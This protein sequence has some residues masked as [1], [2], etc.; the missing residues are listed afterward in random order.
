M[1]SCIRS[2][3]G[4]VGRSASSR[5]LGAK[6]PPKKFL[7]RFVHGRIFTL[8]SVGFRARVVSMGR[9]KID[10]TGKR[11]GRLV[12]LHEE[13]RYRTTP[14]WKCECDCGEI[15]IVLGSNLRS[16]GTSSC[17]CLRDEVIRRKSESSVARTPEYSCWVA[18][19]ERTNNPE[20]PSY[21]RYGGVGISMCPQWEDFRKFVSDMGPRPSMH[22]AIERIGNMGNY[23]PDNC[24]WAT[25]EEQGNSRRSNVKVTWKGVSMTVIQWER[26]LGMSKRLLRG[27]IR[28]GWDIERALTEGIPPERV[29]Q[30]LDQARSER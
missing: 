20:H 29:A 7:A 30:V 9:K 5:A 11:F 6:P 27:R 23:E 22:H 21:P 13:G 15:N 3:V 24:R 14:T 16:G 18:M 8:L 17:G 19:K 4:S 1:G 12:V 26:K 2:R 25:P 28:R 10:L